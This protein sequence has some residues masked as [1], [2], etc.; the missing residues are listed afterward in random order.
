MKW[1]QMG[2]PG[3]ARGARGNSSNFSKEAGDENRSWAVQEGDQALALP[4]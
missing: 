2:A 3:P 1:P 4:R